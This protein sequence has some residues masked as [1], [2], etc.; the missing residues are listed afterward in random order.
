MAKDYFQD[1]VPQEGGSRPRPRDTERRSPIRKEEVRRPLEEI[2]EDEQALPE[3]SIRNIPPPLRSRPPRMRDVHDER[4]SADQPVPLRPQSSRLWI[5]I[6]AGVSIIVLFV[7]I[8]FVFRSTTVTVIPRSNTVTF[9]QSAQFTAHPAASAAAGALS[10][11]VEVSDLEDSE[12]VQSNGTEHA[13]IKATGSI[14]ITN[15]YSVAPVKLIK[16]TR[17]QDSSGLIFRVPADVVV[18]GNSGG[19]QGS[20]SVIVVADKPGKQYNIGPTDFTV[21]GLKSNAAMYSGVRAHSNRA[22]TGGFVGDRPAVESGAMQA[23]QAA[24]RTHI[25]QKIHDQIAARTEA[26]VIPD[27]VRITFNSEPG[28]AEAGG[29]VRIHE[30]AHVEMPVFPKEAYAKAIASLVSADAEEASIEIVPGEGYASSAV[31]STAVDLGK[32]PLT[33]KLSGQ[34]LVVWQVDTEALAKA[35]AGIHEAVFQNVVTTFSSIQ[36]AHARIEPFWKSTF[37]SD[38]AKIK[39]IVEKPTPV[40]TP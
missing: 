32:E 24:I 2:H 18:P 40:A 7:L 10:Y 12:V 35:L 29:G 22:M 38:S 37:P 36:E 31:K 5:W 27:L 9:D 15:D 6:A 11:T 3:R 21:P 14:V 1:I 16:N 39:I 13:E 8:L 28:T 30:K 23:A 19:K 33:F 4:T 20:V 25:A 34:V 26:I 17:F